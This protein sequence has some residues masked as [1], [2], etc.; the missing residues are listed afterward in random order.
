MARRYLRK[1][2]LGI[3]P[4]VET[5]IAGYRVCFDGLTF[6]RD[7]VMVE[8]AADPPPPATP[9][10]PKILRLHVLDDCTATPYPTDWEDLAWPSLGPE[11]MTTRL[12]RRPPPHAS[13]LSISVL[14]PNSDFPI[15]GSDELL[16]QYR[17]T[18]FDVELPDDHAVLWHEWRHGHRGSQSD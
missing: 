18:S 16:S 5:E 17:V 8:Y 14:P 3:D 6:L 11:R 10:G 9:F 15:D 2:H 12:E 4:P 1:F 7:K 13:V